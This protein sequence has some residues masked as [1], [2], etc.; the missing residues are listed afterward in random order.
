MLAS[1]RAA[2]RMGSGR[3]R[4]RALLSQSNFTIPSPVGLSCF[5]GWHR[6]AAGGSRW[7]SAA[8]KAADTTEELKK[9]GR[10][11]TEMMETVLETGR[12]GFNEVLRQSL[13]LEVKRTG[14]ISAAARDRQQHA[15]AEADADAEKATGARRR[16][17]DAP[18]V[19]DS[20]FWNP[21]AANS[22]F[23]NK[24][25]YLEQFERL[26]RNDGTKKSYSA[27]EVVTEE[28]IEAY[29]DA[30]AEDGSLKTFQGLSAVLV[31]RTLYANVVK[32][33]L[34]VLQM[35]LGTVDGQT[36]LGRELYLLRRQSLRARWRVSSKYKVDQQIVEKLMRRVMADHGSGPDIMGAE[37]Q[38]QMYQNIITLI[39]RLVF[40]L[41]D[42]CQLRVLGHTV[43][44]NIEIDD[45]LAEAPGW[46]I[47]LDSGIFGRFDMAE[48]RAFISSFVDDLLTDEHINIKGMPGV[49]ERK[50]YVNVVML[51]LDLLETACNHLRLHL[52]GI[53]FRPALDDLKKKR[54]KTPGPGKK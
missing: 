34:R 2:M 51:M 27:L 10:V 12:L 38:A 45:N 48:K 14:R 32:V 17:P 41:T 40:D 9:Q 16:H 22:P 11:A 26:R 15:A 53:S 19:R 25:K 43:T 31:P 4:R 47:S 30:L 6:C 1:R 36:I 8:S 29:V 49:L 3:P 42:S 7:D 18:K 50:L 13:G 37:V 23:M 35:S 28:E 46:D 52:A 5:T 33:I 24:Q 54:S 44:I 39:F 20:S 21:Y